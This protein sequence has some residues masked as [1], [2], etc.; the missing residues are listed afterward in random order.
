[1][2]EAAV[3]AEVAGWLKANW[4]PALGLVEW[5]TKLA[6]SGWGVPH[7]PAQWHGRDLSDGLVPVV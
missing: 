6:A 2:N 7:W 4:D 5:R 3:R 1:M